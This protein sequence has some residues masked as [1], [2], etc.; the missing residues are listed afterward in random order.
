MYLLRGFSERSLDRCRHTW[1]FKR[2]LKGM[3]QRTRSVVNLKFPGSWTLIWPFFICPSPLWGRGLCTTQQYRNIFLVATITSAQL[4]IVWTV[5]SGFNHFAWPLS[6]TMTLGNWNGGD[7]VTLFKRT[8]MLV[9][10]L[11]WHLSLEGRQWEE[12]STR[13]GW[14]DVGGRKKTVLSLGKGLKVNPAPCTEPV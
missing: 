2:N 3:L 12:F 9:Q 1:G 4:L 7:R 10:I 6:L 13:P 5:E 11:V 8:L 14:S